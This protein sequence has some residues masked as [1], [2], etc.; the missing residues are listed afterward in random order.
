MIPIGGAM[1]LE[2]KAGL[3]LALLVAGCASSPP[4]PSHAPLV[5]MTDA[6]STTTITSSLEPDAQPAETPRVGKAQRALGDD[7][8][9][10]LDPKRTASREGQRPQAFADWK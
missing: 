4:A 5:P 7:A 8:Q 10:A 1:K 3:F 9:R 2:Q 6:V